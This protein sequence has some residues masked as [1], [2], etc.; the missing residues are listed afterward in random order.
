MQRGLIVPLGDYAY[1]YIE[2]NVRK[3]SKPLQI[4]SG[5]KPHK[6]GN[7]TKHSDNIVLEIRRLHETCKMTRLEI[8]DHFADLGITLKYAEINGLLQYHTRALLVPKD[9]NV[10]YWSGEIR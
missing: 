8:I 4:Y 9:T 2:P 6:G 1:K 5:P 7:K 10:P 3:P